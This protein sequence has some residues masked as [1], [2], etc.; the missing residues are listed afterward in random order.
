MKTVPSF[1]VIVSPSRSA[2]T[3]YKSASSALLSLIRSNRVSMKYSFS[4]GTTSFDAYSHYII[5]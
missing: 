3:S 1:I 5:L 4:T 2:R